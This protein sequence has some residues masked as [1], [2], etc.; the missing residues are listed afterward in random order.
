MKVLTAD[1]EEN[2]ERFL[3]EQRAMG[4]LTGHPNIVGVLQVGETA[5][6]LS[7]PGDAVPPAGFAGRAH[8]P[9]RSSCRWTRGCGSG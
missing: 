6:R 5:E 4:L 7:I 3:R 8:P 1:L 2:R 9:T